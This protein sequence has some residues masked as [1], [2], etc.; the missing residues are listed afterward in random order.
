MVS[1]R[2]I[3]YFRS[4]SWEK[5]PPT[6]DVVFLKEV[7][8]HMPVVGVKEATGANLSITVTNGSASPPPSELKE[9]KGSWYSRISFLLWFFI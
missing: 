6:P 7:S 3:G 4:R 9:D 2:I 5:P 8:V 1:E